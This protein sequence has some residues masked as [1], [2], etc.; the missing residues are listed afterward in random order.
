M[1]ISTMVVKIHT[2]ATPMTDSLR[3]TWADTFVQVLG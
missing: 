2:Y 1:D 3:I